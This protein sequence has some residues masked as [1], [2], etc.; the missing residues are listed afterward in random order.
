M[1]NQSRNALSGVRLV[2]FIVVAAL[3]ALLIAKVLAFALH[4]VFALVG[5]LIAF[6]IAV[7]LL[8]WL[9]GKITGGSSN[10]RDRYDSERDEFGR[11]RY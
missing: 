3:F 4:L 1:M 10:A 6:V 5:Y 8:M 7:V 2:L 9:W 11:R